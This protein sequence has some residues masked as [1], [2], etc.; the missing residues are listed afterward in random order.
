MKHSRLKRVLALVL[1]AALICG[2]NLSSAYAV[3]TQGDTVQLDSAEPYE[4]TELVRAMI[5]LEQDSTL[6]V[7]QASG[8]ALTSQAAV[9]YRQKL[10]RA[11]E[12]MASRIS[13]QCLAGEPLD[14]VWNLTL[15]ANAIS[16][17]VA[18]GKLEEI[19]QVVR[20]IV[21]G[22]LE[23]DAGMGTMCEDIVHRP[24]MGIQVFTRLRIFLL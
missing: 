20:H 1:V 10:D 6:T 15:S 14:V 5:V 23:G 3:N 22:E 8:E 12:Q 4:A 16:A 17:N 9:Q 13:R 7:M 24:A 2:M 11:Q 21:P 19:R 18:Y